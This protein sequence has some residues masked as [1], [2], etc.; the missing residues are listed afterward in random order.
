MN[1]VFGA[2]SHGALI[3]YTY[4]FDVMMRQPVSYIDR[5]VRGESPSDLPVQSPI[6]Y[7]LSI[8]LKVATALGL[9]VPPTP[10]ARADEVIE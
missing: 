1:P 5:I 10:L 8:N 7:E 3:S 2:A 4:A 6:K 9:E